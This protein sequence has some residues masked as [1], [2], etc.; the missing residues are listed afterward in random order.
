MN[1]V[2]IDTGAFVA[3]QIPDDRWH[4]QAKAALQAGV[5]RRLPFVTTNQ[6]IGETYTLL[7]YSHSHAMAWRFVEAVRVSRHLE[8]ARIDAELERE[9][10][11][12][13]RQY[14]DQP[15]SFVDGTSFALMR[16]R[17]LRHAFAFDKH[18][19]TAGFVRIPVDAEVP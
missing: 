8:I 7:R 9:A 2:F 14:T 11:N 17:R 10:W 15:F 1:A 18:F 6:V 16:Q 5:A 13:L 12:T 4:A 3:I 19:A